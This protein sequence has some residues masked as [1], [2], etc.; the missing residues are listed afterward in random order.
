VSVLA[1]ALEGWAP[2][3]VETVDTVGAW[4]VAA[5]SGML[6]LPDTAAADG[7]PVPPL[8]HWL[9][10]LDHPAQRELG[11]DGH[12][13]EGHFL[14]PVPDR[15]RMFGGGRLRVEEPMRVGARV[16]RRTEITDVRV[17]SG[18]SGEM[19]FVTL[20]HAFHDA[21]DDRLL[22]T[23]EQ[24]IVYRSQPAGAVRCIP[25]PDPVPPPEHDHSFRIAAG[26]Q[27]LFRFSAL[28]YNT[29]RI[30]YDREYAASVEGYPGLVVQGP[31]L[32]MLALEIPRRHRPGE[33]LATFDYRLTSPAFDGA[34]VWAGGSATADG[35]DV[36]AGSTAGPES[37]RGRVTLR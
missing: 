6:D 24:D 33:R 21:S 18:R 22:L 37:V 10:F 13:A 12:P 32:A 11:E 31:L 14:P 36:A 25:A 16:R 4:A 3:P 9:A 1:D 8:W 27:L 2:E 30:H 17:K 29:H 35:L 7:D 19:A 34:D 5:F 23:E 26:P 15:R 28:T 20:R